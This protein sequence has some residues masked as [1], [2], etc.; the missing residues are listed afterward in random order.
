L[1]DASEF[2]AQIPPLAAIKERLRRDLYAYVLSRPEA[3]GREE[4]AQAVG[5]ARDKLLDAGL[6]DVEYRRRPDLVCGMN[7]SMA[8]G[9]LAG[10]GAGNLETRLGS[11]TGMCCVPPAPPSTRR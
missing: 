5:I 1:L 11:Q 10:L 2:T 8:R 7:L 4:A 6:L 3:V 9:Q